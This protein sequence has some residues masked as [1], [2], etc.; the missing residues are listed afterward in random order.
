[1]SFQPLPQ[2]FLP[3]YFGGAE[4]LSGTSDGDCRL[5]KALAIT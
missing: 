4:S 1:M 3:T 5:F 2:F